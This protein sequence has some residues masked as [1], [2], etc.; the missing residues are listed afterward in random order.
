[1]AKSTTFAELLE[2]LDFELDQKKEVPDTAEADRF[3][4]LPQLKHREL[5]TIVSNHL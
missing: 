4:S 1:M 5:S 2:I 3:R